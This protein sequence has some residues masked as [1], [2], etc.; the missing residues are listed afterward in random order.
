MNIMDGELES[1]E[2]LLKGIE[3]K[4]DSDS[5]DYEFFKE[6]QFDL[7]RWIEDIKKNN[8]EVLTKEDLEFRIHIL[9][10]E[11]ECREDVLEDDPSL[12]DKD[13][14]DIK[15]NIRKIGEWKRELRRL[16]QAFV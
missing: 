15:E 8:T 13:I 6:Y 3:S 2:S 16:K 1:N 14:K 5:E 9:Q 11:M 12:K 7:L 4:C 10:N